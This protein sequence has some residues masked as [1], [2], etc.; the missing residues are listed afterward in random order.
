VEQVSVSLQPPPTRDRLATA[1]RR[2]APDRVRLW[3]LLTARTRG[4]WYVGG[5]CRATRAFRARWRSVP[6]SVRRDALGGDT[7]RIALA[8]LD[9]LTGKTG[10]FETA[11]YPDGTPVAYVATIQEFGYPAG[12]IP[13]RP[14]HAPH[15]RR[16]APRWAETMAAGA[17][18]ALT[19]R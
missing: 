11:K 18:A 8:G 14:D 19:A 9:G 5:S 2:D 7:L 3:A 1:A 4:G 13:A 17:K 15:G 6:M 16:S 10:Y 12:G